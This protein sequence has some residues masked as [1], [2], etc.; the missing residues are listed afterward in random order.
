[1]VTQMFK[2]NQSRKL[3]P[4]RMV[5]KQNLP[6]CANDAS[7]CFN[8]TLC[9]NLLEHGCV[10]NVKNHKISN[11][12]EIGKCETCSGQ[13]HHL[14]SKLFGHHANSTVVAVSYTTETLF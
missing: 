3:N 10:Y 8:C 4:G 7:N 13:R 11:Y 2:S 12:R 6:N 14:C 5:E 9:F 1:M